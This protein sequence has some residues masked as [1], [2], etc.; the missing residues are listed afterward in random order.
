M[1]S[2]RGAL[3][4]S[5]RAPAED[6]YRDD[7]HCI[8]ELLQNSDDN[9]YAD[10][11]EPTWVLHYAEAMAPMARCWTANN[12]QGMSALDVRAICDA[13]NSSKGG[14]GARIGRKG[15]G[16]KSAFRLSKCPHVLSGGFSFKFDLDANGLLGYVLLELLTP[17]ALDN[18]PL[19]PRKLW[20][21]QQQT[22]FFAARGSAPHL[23]SCETRSSSRAVPPLSPQG[24][25]ACAGST[26]RSKSA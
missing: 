22:V 10:D 12:E 11:V 21:E 9:M 14:S 1:D 13:G 3:H 26:K 23:T 2:L 6:L 25:A 4:R 18:L 24:Y 7:V 19:R 8:S 5:L 20:S 17:S 16:F 15:V